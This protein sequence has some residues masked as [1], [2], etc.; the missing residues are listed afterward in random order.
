MFS[1]NFHNVMISSRFGTFAEDSEEKRSKSLE[2]KTVSVW[3]NILH[4]TNI[5]QYKNKYYDAQ[6]STVAIPLPLV[7]HMARAAIWSGYFFRYHLHVR[8]QFKSYELLTDAFANK[9]KNPLGFSDLGF[10]TNTTE[11]GTHV[12]TDGTDEGGLT[13]TIGGIYDLDRG[14]FSS[15]C[16]RLSVLS[17]IGNGFTSIPLVF[18]AM[19]SLRKLCLENS[20][21]SHVSSIFGKYLTNIEILSL[22]GNGISSVS[23]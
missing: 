7:G 22:R 4:P 18:G 15:F 1:L 21:I 20:S 9:S 10:D 14:Q 17:L 6:D 16:A 23:G 2:R 11:S 12:D 13:I 5:D 8:N 19:S 3:S